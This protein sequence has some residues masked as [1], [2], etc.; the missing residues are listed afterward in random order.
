MSTTY[1][2]R[3]DSVA[4]R[5]IA[6]F[7]ANPDEELSL[8]DITEKFDCTRG[9]I[10]TLLVPA[11]DA[12]LLGRYQGTDGEWIYRAGPKLPKANGID[13]DA[14]HGHGRGQGSAPPQHRRVNASAADLPDPQAVVIRDNVP[15][16]GHKQKIDWLP[17]LKRLTKPGQSAELPLAARNTLSVAV[18][19]ARKDKLGEY[20]LRVDKRANTVTVWRTA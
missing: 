6:F 11:R 10:H 16:P 20:T 18:T 17:L 12:G 4:A 7:Q 19:Q 15:I 5:C 1:T 14:V 2:P 9:N 13:M 3:A 8:D